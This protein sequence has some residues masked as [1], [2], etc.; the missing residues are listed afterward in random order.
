[1]GR[2]TLCNMAI[3]AR[4]RCGM[5]APD[6]TTF[7]YLRGREFAPKG[8]PLD[9]AMQDWTELKSDPGAQFDREGSSDATTI[10][11]FVT[12]GTSPEDAL[13]IDGRVPDPAREQSPGR[14][15]YI[16]GAVEYMGLGPGRRLTDIAIDRVF[17]GSCTNA[18]I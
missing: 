13:P 1:E 3:E 5:V 7:E 8:D 6:A 18:R 10:P 2:M 16:K 15:K 12:W 4:S 9:Q 11:P 17:I 14:A